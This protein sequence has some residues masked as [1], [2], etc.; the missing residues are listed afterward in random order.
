MLARKAKREKL[1]KLVLTAAVAVGIV[2]L[3]TGMESRAEGDDSEIIEQT[4]EQTESIG[5]V[6]TSNG[7]SDTYTISFYI[8]ETK[9]QITHSGSGDFTINVEADGTDSAAFI[10]WFYKSSD[11]SYVF[12]KDDTIDVSKIFAAITSPSLH[13]VYAPCLQ[14]SVDGADSTTLAVSSTSGSPYPTVYTSYPI[15]SKS[16]YSLV[17]WSMKDNNNETATGTNSSLTFYYEFDETSGHYQLKTD[18]NYGI[19]SSTTSLELTTYWK[20][21]DTKQLIKVVN[22]TGNALTIDGTSIAADASVFLSLDSSSYPETTDNGY[23]FFSDGKAVSIDKLITDSSTTQYTKYEDINNVQYNTVT[24]TESN[25]LEYADITYQVN[26]P[27]GTASNT[28][29]N[30][31]AENVSSITLHTPDDVSGYVFKGW[32]TSANATAAEYSADEQVT[33]SK[34]ATSD[35]YSTLYGVWKKLYSFSYEGSSTTESVAEGDSVTV[36]A[37][38]TLNGFTFAGWEYSS[39]LYEPEVTFTMPAENVSLEATWKIAYTNIPKAGS[40]YLVN[41]YSYIL[42]ESLTV[43]GD[44]SVYESGISFYVNAENEYVFN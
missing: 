26:Y 7:D 36:P 25:C 33:L 44:S 34:L 38:P 23:A 22:E 21:S 4:E 40:Y 18:T 3:G 8:G 13:V 19:T 28:V 30:R 42:D 1:A 11:S 31:V 43:D 35:G 14:L 16:G 9:F 10:G 17:S 6:T 24:L 41:G 29:I 20:L 39:T 27:E 15:S 32:A 5:K 12:M 37:A 2:L